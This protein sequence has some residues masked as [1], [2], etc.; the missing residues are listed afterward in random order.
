MEDFDFSDMSN[1][2]LEKQLY[3][4]V[5]FFEKNLLKLCRIIR[6]EIPRKMIYRII[7]KLYRI[8]TKGWR[9]YDADKIIITAAGN[10][11]HSFGT[12]FIYRKKH[13]KNK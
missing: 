5:I 13:Q 10:D 1:E 12:L 8:R 6:K 3:S 11:F 7:S 4:E 9:W 2:Q